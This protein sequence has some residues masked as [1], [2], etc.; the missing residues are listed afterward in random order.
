ML[1]KDQPGSTLTCIYCRAVGVSFDRDHVIPEAFGKFKNN[2][3]LTCVCHECNQYFGRTLELSLARDSGEGFLRFRRGVKP[4][5]KVSQLKH[6]RI[7]FTVHEPGP[8]MGA[9]AIFVPDPS[10]KSIEPQPL[11]QVAFKKNE[12]EWIWI[13]E[14]DLTPE[15]LAPYKGA[16]MR[17]VAPSL[18]KQQ[19]LIAKLRNLGFPFTPKGDLGIPHAPDGTV[20]T[21]QTYHIDQI[22]LRAVGK[23]A[24]NY[25]AY[26]E[27][28]NF[29]LS[30]DF[31]EFRAWVRHGRE[32]RFHPRAVAVRQPILFSD[33][34]RWRQTSGHLIA[35]DWNTQ[36]DGLLVQVSLFN[37]LTYRVL[38]CVHYSGIW[39]NFRKGHHFDLESLTVSSLV[40]TALITPTAS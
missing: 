23:I 12:S 7:Q 24:F 37:S 10:G 29:V 20:L 2:L 22:I 33:S 19:K 13:P 32:P 18:E 30:S 9:Q 4:A 21:K 15:S 28:P 25:V 6:I 5:M 38:I 14:N 34:R 17:V 27:G 11:P 16:D 26:A 36:G 3:V 1:H 8:W 39:Q 31:D 35:F 40:G